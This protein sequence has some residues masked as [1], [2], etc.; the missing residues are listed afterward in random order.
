M[1]KWA[2]WGKMGPLLH[3]IQKEILAAFNI[4]KKM[5]MEIQMTPESKKDLLQKQQEKPERKKEKKKGKTRKK[6]PINDT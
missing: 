2:V 6:S 1:R 5:L 4:R 3:Q